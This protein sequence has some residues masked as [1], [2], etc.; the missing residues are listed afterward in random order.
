VIADVETV[1]FCISEPIFCLEVA[2]GDLRAAL[3][4]FH[5]ARKGGGVNG[6]FFVVL[7]VDSSP[8]PDLHY[9]TV[10]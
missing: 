4:D 10:A 2:G 9:C 1:K 7:H 6:Q 8:D 5:R 3:V